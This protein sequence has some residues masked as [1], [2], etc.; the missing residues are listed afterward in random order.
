MEEE[1]EEKEVEEN[2]D[3]KEVEEEEEEGG[4]EATRGRMDVEDRRLHAH[5]GDIAQNVLEKSADGGNRVDQLLNSEA[6]GAS[7]GLGEDENGDTARGFLEEQR[8]SSPTRGNGRSTDGQARPES[9]PVSAQR[10]PPASAT[11]LGGAGRGKEAERTI[12]AENAIIPGARLDSK[13]DGAERRERVREGQKSGGEAEVVWAEGVKTH[14]NPSREEGDAAA[15]ADGGALGVHTGGSTDGD[16]RGEGYADGEA[17]SALGGLGDAHGDGGDGSP[18]GPGDDHQPALEWQPRK[19]DLV[20][21]ERRMTPGVNKPGGTARVVK[22]DAAAGTVDV[23]YVVEGGWERGIDI[24]YVNPAVLDL[25]E[26]R[27]T[28]GRC[29][30]CGS[31]RVDCR[32]GCEFYTTP[33]SPRLLPRPPSAFDAHVLPGRSRGAAALG[34][35]SGKGS[36]R[37][38]DRRRG[39]G[40]HQHRS[41]ASDGGKVD[42]DRHHSKRRRRRLPEKWDEEGEP[43]P[44][45][46]EAVDEGGDSG[47]GG[48]PFEGERRSQSGSPRSSSGG[49]SSGN[50]SSTDDIIGARDRK[51]SVRSKQRRLRLPASGSE[52]GSD[53]DVELLDDYSI[54]RGA[55]SRS[56]THDAAGFN[57]GGGSGASSDSGSASERSRRLSSVGSD[58]ASADGSDGGPGEQEGGGSPH[59]GVAG[60]GWLGDAAGAVKAG[61]ALFLVPEGEEA[62]HMLPSD[63]PDP[64]RGVTDPVVLRKEFDL[65]LQRIAER[66]TNK[67]ER[68]VADVCR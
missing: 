59:G 68:D 52:S 40:R 16:A 12:L 51:T 6:L 41:H 7:E 3:E 45:D 65:L 29:C 30:H 8:M 44:G 62:A 38:K 34:S 50:S 19:G 53:S 27:P 64:T 22:V 66:D 58:D 63:I 18:R 13:E 54:R 39:S 1:E 67:L 61:T 35:E 42:Q 26:K 20:E 49:T 5:D 43:V 25:N 23:R 46:G 17:S 56:G 48:L 33:R 36:R 15:G 11:G 9:C 57:N 24:V 55:A 37:G 28:L 10:T 60:R 21:V 47:G 14:A 2:A 31:L 32:Q 4:E